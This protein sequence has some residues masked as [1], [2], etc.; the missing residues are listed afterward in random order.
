[1][2]E[3]MAAPLPWATMLRTASIRCGLDE[4]LRLKLA[5]VRPLV[6]GGLVNGKQGIGVSRDV[7]EMYLGEFGERVCRGH[8]QLSHRVD[9]CLVHGAR[10]RFEVNISAKSKSPAATVSS[11]SGRPTSIQE[12]SRLGFR[13][14]SRSM[15]WEEEVARGKP[16][17]CVVTL[18]NPQW[19]VREVAPADEPSWGELFRGYRRYYRMPDDEASGSVGVEEVASRANPQLAGLC[20]G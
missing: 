20:G 3:R 19:T 13:A 12:I 18:N 15:C 10:L 1:M 17:Q 4:D 7:A 9:E 2:S 16:P 14:A 5:P 6:L 11:T 8:P